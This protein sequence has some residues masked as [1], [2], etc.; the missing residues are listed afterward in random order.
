MAPELVV[1]VGAGVAGL[2]CAQALI[3]GGRTAVVLE[4]ARGVGGRCATR[5]LGLE[6]QPV[7]F[8]VSFLHGRDPGFLA[9]LDAVDAQ[10]LPGWPSIV[11]GTGRPCQP[12]ALVGG[13]RRLAFAEGLSVLPKHLARGLDVRTEARVT[14]LSQSGEVVRLTLEQ[15][16][17]IEARDVVLAL[18]AEQAQ[19]LLDTLDD[20]SPAVQSARALL[21]MNRSEPCLTLLAGYGPEAP[22]PAWHAC[23][24]EGSDV[25]QLIA[26]DSSKRERPAFLALVFQAHARWSRAHLDDEGWPAAL[27]AEAARLLGPWAASP[28]LTQ[29]HRWRYART[30][31]GAELSAPL[32]L[33]LPGGARVGIAGEL[34]APGGGVEAGWLS[35]R[36]LAGQILAEGDG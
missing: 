11:E 27:L 4:R 34:F 30:D 1:V 7:D 28:R 17:P 33:R 26:H 22:A 23:Y 24:P 18:A 5:R 6:G 13:G 36:M 12:H 8:G 14:A 20:A 31:R 16:E 10:P 9:L 25:I 3:A 32:L 35:G 29:A 2:S 21:G 19:T 15:G